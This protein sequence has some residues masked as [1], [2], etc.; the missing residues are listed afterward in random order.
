VAVSVAVP[1]HSALLRFLFQFQSFGIELAGAPLTTAAAVLDDSSGHSLR[2]SLQ[3][4]T[5]FAAATE[6]PANASTARAVAAISRLA[7]NFASLPP[8]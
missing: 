2:F 1:L 7:M 8:D 3:R 5:F 6:V 4:V